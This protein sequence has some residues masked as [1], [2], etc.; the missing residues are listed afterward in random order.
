MFGIF[1][2]T[3]KVILKNLSIIKCVSINF[4][5]FLQKSQ[6]LNEYELKIVLIVHPNQQNVGYVEIFCPDS[7]AKLALIFVQNRQNSINRAIE[8]RQMSIN[9][10]EFC[11]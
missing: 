1:G 10:F 7:S 5:C 8:Q 11:F 6:H 4:D 2:L 9:S 3:L